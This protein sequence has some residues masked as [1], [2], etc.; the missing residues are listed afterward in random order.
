MPQLWEDS[1]V[2][3][4]LGDFAQAEPSGKLHIIG[5][6]ISIIGFDPALNTTAPLHVVAIVDVEPRHAGEAFS[7]S[8]ELRNVDLDQAV[9]VP[10]GPLG[11]PQALRLSQVVTVQRPAMVG[12]HLPDSL[13]CRTQMTMGFP[14]GLPLAPGYRYAWR[15]T[16]DG[17]RRK[18]WRTEFYVPQLAAPPVFGGPAGPADIPGVELPDEDDDSEG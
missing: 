2:T 3:L 14:T 5:G 4:L 17:N 1:Q 18:H 9:S 6:G 16:I 11:Q 10:A 15:L 7:L 12:V 8:L 13:A